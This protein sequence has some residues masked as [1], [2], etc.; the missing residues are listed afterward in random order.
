ME[1]VQEEE[2]EHKTGPS[3]GADLR[4]DI[5]ISFEEAYLGVKKTITLYREETC[6]VCH[7]SGAKPGSKVDTCNVCGGTRTNKTGSINFIW[8]NA[9]F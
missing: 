1:D 2:K 5:E 4:N 9:N 3:K 6:D 7:G 8:A